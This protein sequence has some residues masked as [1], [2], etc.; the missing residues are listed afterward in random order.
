MNTDAN[1]RLNGTV[2]KLAETVTDELFPS[3]RSAVE[4][5]DSFK[6]SHLNSFPHRMAGN[7]QYFFLWRI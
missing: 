6:L 5:N 3:T 7:R 4:L 2:G 1:A